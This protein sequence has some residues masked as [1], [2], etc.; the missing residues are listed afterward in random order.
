MYM[1]VCLCVYVHYV[2]TWYQNRALDHLDLQLQMALGCYGVLG[3]K[4]RSS[5]GTTSSFY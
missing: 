1:S 3:T 4:P 5:A 2:Q